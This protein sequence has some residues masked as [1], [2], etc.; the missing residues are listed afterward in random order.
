MTDELNCNCIDRESS[1]FPVGN[2][3]IETIEY[4]SWSASEVS[5]VASAGKHTAKLARIQHAGP[6]LDVHRECLH[7]QMMLSLSLKNLFLRMLSSARFYS[8]L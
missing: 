2:V 5:I 7:S 8:E 4:V 3:G 1:G 6:N